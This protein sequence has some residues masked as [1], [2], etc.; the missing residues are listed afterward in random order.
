MALRLILIL[1]LLVAPVW[2]DYAEPGPYKVQESQRKLKDGRHKRELLT[3]FLVP[4]SKGRLPLVILS[5]GLGGN[6]KSHRAIATHLASHGFLVLAP[7]HPTSNTVWAQKVYAKTRGSLV[8][9]ARQTMAT[10]ALHPQSLLGRPRDVSALIDLAEKWNRDKKD[11]LYG[12]I[13][14]ERIAVMGHSY[15]AYTTLAVCGAR[16]I[17]DHTKPAE[18]PGRGLAPSLRDPRVKVGIALS[19]QGPG[20]GF[21]SEES[22]SEIRV[23]MLCLSGSRDKAGDFVKGQNL[24]AR[25]R[26]RAFE[27]MPAGDKFYAWLW[28]TGHMGFGDFESNPPWVKKT[29]KM[30]VPENKDVLKITGALSTAFLKTYLQQ[31]SAARELL[32][33]EYATSLKGRVVKRIGW[34]SK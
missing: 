24:P 11:P 16:P 18:K 32:S 23:P 7:D 28:N 5:H 3:R 15:G 25:N 34:T 17:L 31:D 6:N 20:N 10:V 26:Y 29:A 4:Q 30:M 1:A 13:D 12:R 33:K 14:L 19:P 8:S 21:F 22:Y 2:G 27:L 9:R